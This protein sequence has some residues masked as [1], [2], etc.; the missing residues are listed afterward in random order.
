[1]DEIN[2]KTPNLL[3]KREHELRNWTQQDVA[4]KVDVEPNAVSQWERG[5]KTPDAYNRQKLCKLFGKTPIELGFYQDSEDSNKQRV[6]R[7]LRQQEVPFPP[8]WNV[9]YEPNPFFTGR[10]QIIQQLH[11]S[12]LANETTV[13]TQ[14]LSGLGGV[15]KTQIAVEYCYRFRSEYKAVLWASADSP[16]VLM[17][18]LVDIAKLLKLP[19]SA[20][21][22]QQPILNALREWMRKQPYWL[23]VLDNLED[24]E[25]VRRMVPPARRGHVLLTMR[26]QLTGNYPKI[27]VQDMQADE[28]ALLVL[29]KALMLAPDANL[30]RAEEADRETAR[31]ISRTLGG[32]PLA[33]EQAG[34]YIQETGCGLPGYLE[35]Y[36]VRR[37][38][39]LKYRGEFS[40]HYPESVATTW[41]L[42]FERIQKADAAAADLLRAS[43]FLYPDAI[44]EELFVKGAKELGPVFQSLSLQTVPFDRII[45]TILRYSL[46]RRN[47]RD[48]TLSIHRLVQAVLMD[49]MDQETQHR[50]AE[51]VIK[52]VNSELPS[53]AL[54][55]EP[56]QQYSFQAQNCV[57]LVNKW[58][59]TF[60]EAAQIVCAAGR[61][62]YGDGYYT[63]AEKLCFRALA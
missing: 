23:L 45:T 10:E 44:P 20:T 9:P 38:E 43:A 5:V 52:A 46:I 6:N 47:P 13:L 25:T 30:D 31:Q 15:G 39:L 58:N 1:M 28:G 26:T 49:G 33:L 16:E 34:A 12:L 51:R 62:L 57:Q 61:Y 40:S 56:N 22:D 59:F 36:R 63:Q 2:K 41:S 32:L 48:K 11:K 7:P 3:L 24:I 21:K 42:S 35:Q 27:D 19:I 4:E 18:N 8:I 60:L 14:A 37:A 50:W 53:D 54:L 55:D 17:A 29:R